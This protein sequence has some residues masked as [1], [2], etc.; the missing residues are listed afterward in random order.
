MDP[1]AEALLDEF[2][3]RVDEAINDA[4][5][6]I[7]RHIWNRAHLNAWKVASAVAVGCEPRNPVVEPPHARWAIDLVGRSVQTVLSRFER[8]EVG[9]GDTARAEFV[10]RRKVADFL[11]MSREQ[12]SNPN[13]SIPESMRHGPFIP[14]AYIF[15]QTKGL[16]PFKDKDW[17]L[18]NTL[19]EMV[20]I[21]ALHRLSPEEARQQFKTRGGDVYTVG[22]QWQ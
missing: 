18:R 11:A 8:G 15:K 14:Y 16:Q 13:L 6:R 17:L 7:E 20:R 3:Q 10:V 19:E 5:G 1:G 12:R 9:G 21:G 22:P 2:D 4:K